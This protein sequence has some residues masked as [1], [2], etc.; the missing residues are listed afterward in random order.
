MSWPTVGHVKIEGALETPDRAW[1][2]EIIKRG[3]SRWYR[4]VNGGNELGWLTIAA[5]ERVLSVAGVDMAEVRIADD[6]RERV[7]HLVGDHRDEVLLR[8]GEFNL[9]LFCG[10]VPG[11][12]RAARRCRSAGR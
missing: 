11:T 1:R 3:Q 4:V 5:V 7:P 2:V 12:V 6:G 10:A 9:E 8:P